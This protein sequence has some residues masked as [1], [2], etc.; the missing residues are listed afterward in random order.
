MVYVD[1]NPLARGIA[2][3]LGVPLT[4]PDI[5]VNGYPSV[6]H[7][8]YPYL[9]GGV[10]GNIDYAVDATCVIP[11]DPV[12]AIE[13]SKR[14][15]ISGFIRP[16]FSLDA[17]LRLAGAYTNANRPAGYVP[18]TPDDQPD[19]T[20]LIQGQKVC[21][22]D[23]EHLPA[24]I[25]RVLSK[26]DDLKL[27]LF[28][29]I[30]VP[31]STTVGALARALIAFASSSVMGMVRNYFTPYPGKNPGNN[32]SV[33]KIIHVVFNAAENNCLAKEDS[34]EFIKFLN[35]NIIPFYKKAPGTVVQTFSKMTDNAGAGSAYFP[36]I[37]DDCQWSQFNEWCVLAA[38]LDRAEK[39]YRKANQTSIADTL[40]VILLRHLQWITD[41]CGDDGTA[42][43][44]VSFPTPLPADKILP[45]LVGTGFVRHFNV[46]S[47]TPLQ[48]E[49]PLWAFHP[50]CLAGLAGI[51]RA[52]SIAD[53]IEAR[54][55]SLVP[56]W[57]WMNSVV[58]GGDVDKVWYVRANG[59]YVNK[60]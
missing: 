31:T 37:P 10:G 56:Q 44:F 6:Y 16:M 39:L 58:D 22:Y 51:P 52:Q 3:A 33:G 24:Q 29:G 38:A 53:V 5:P 4:N 1:I 14:Y 2:L 54:W 9:A 25:W 41:V 20:A 8:G 32:R 11:A 47:G 49:F 12:K 43:Y 59:T 26:R 34:D 45:T 7:F 21:G 36:A 19:G 57:S 23:L 15:L 27:T 46:Y 17:P 30:G 28:G 18:Q 42:P 60:P 35:G 48:T 13:C 50:L 40:K 55:K